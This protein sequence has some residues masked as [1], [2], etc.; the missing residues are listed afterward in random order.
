MHSAGAAHARTP[1]LPSPVLGG[2]KGRHEQ[3][4]ARRQ[5]GHSPRPA[6][7]L[8]AEHDEEAERRAQEGA[9]P[10]QH[11]AGQRRLHLAGERVG[12]SSMRERVNFAC[13]S[14]VG[15]RKAQMCASRNAAGSRNAS[16]CPSIHPSIHPQLV[17]GVEGKRER[18]RRE[19]PLPC[20]PFHR[21]PHSK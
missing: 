15:W 2:R 1:R 13:H 16:N 17:Q 5:Q 4:D 9:R 19:P 12:P 10:A 11:H 6:R 3:R 7:D 20:P 14:M 18:E 21:G 8:A